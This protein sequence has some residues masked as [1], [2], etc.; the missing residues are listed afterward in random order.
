[1]LSYKRNLFDY[2][3]FYLYSTSQSLSQYC[4]KLLSL[5]IG[6]CSMVTDL[7]LKAI[8]DGCQNLTSVNISWCD[9]ITENGKYYFHVCHYFIASIHD[10]GF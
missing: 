3:L 2:I 7:S 9:G 6:S 4:K 1:M 5:D 10:V 8:S